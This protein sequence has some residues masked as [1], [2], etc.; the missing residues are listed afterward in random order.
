[1]KPDLLIVLAHAAVQE[2]YDR[3]LPLWKRHGLPIRVVTER[4][5]PLKSNGESWVGMG[6]PGIIGQG[7]ADRIKEAVRITAMES[8]VAV[9]LEYDCF[10]LDRAIAFPKGLHGYIWHNTEPC[11][12]YSPRF[13]GAPWRLDSKSAGRMLAVAD[14]YPDLTEGGHSDRINSALAW[15][16]NVP[17]LPNREK[18]W[19]KVITPEMLPE[20]Q[21]ELE[22]GT[23]YWHGIKDEVTLNLF[24]EYIQ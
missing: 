18:S 5:C 7:M 21:K 19:C 8:D 11:R 14:E 1:M 17:M 9:I 4:D 22:S 12:F 13:C 2:T 24:T 6:N 3:H 15:M 10:M 20:V 16:A 23:R